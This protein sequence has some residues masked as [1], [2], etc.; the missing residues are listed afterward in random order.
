MSGVFAVYSTDK[1]IN[2]AETIYYGLYALQHRGQQSAGIAVR[3]K[4]VIEWY[5]AKGLVP[6]IFTAEN[7]DTLPG[8]AGIGHVRYSSAGNLS[9]G[10]IEPLV[11]KYI[12]GYM[13]IA[14]NGRI[15]NANQLR[16]ELEEAGYMFHTQ[17]D[18]EVMAALLTKYR[19]SSEH[20]ED[21]VEHM[22]EHIKGAYAISMITPRYL[23]A[24]R[25]P[26]GI[27]PLCI[28][29]IE[30][31]T[32]I[33]ASESAAIDAVGG[34]FVR[35]VLPGELVMID[36]KGI[37]S[38]ML[39][40]NKKSSLCIF[41]YVYFARPDSI[42]DGAATHDARV[43]AGRILAKEFPV[44]ADVIIG[45]P[46]GGVDMA[47]GYA[48]ESNIPLALGLLRNKY[49]GRTFIAPQ[50][51]SREMA[52][53]I[54]FNPIK[55]EVKGKRVILIDDSIVRGTTT[56]VLVKMFRDA[57]AKEVHLRVGSPPYKY[58]CYYGVDTSSRAQLL[59]S[60]GNKERIRQ[61]IGSDSLEYIS[62]EGIKKAPCCS[63]LDFCTACFTGNYPTEIPKEEG[64]KQ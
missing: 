11:L 13:A 50:Q 60:L 48:Q 10:F 45:V 38:R 1:K 15:I 5:K 44:D 3:D 4:E 54:K 23:I 31:S 16:K 51:N 14:K 29:K 33:V 12:S 35:D 53:K 8:D 2:I 30:D 43:N 36:S 9:A 20:I 32:Y 49:V 52:V 42:I 26:L 24:F 17:N 55:T 21:A 37:Q 34:E 62:F 56:K 58:P 61:E 47:M 27:R 41:E 19:I 40:N 22:L 39:A 7:L 46:D 18:T 59:A 57:G 6:E 28:G 63:N 25:D 64:D